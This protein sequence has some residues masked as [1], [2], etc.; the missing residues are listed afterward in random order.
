MVLER[1][2]EAFSPV[3]SSAVAAIAIGSGGLCLSNYPFSCEESR[4]LSDF[5]SSTPSLSSFING[6]LREQNTPTEF[7]DVDGS[8]LPFSTQSMES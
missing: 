8:E 3:V 1:P 2:V 5:G 7:L 4:D 6:R